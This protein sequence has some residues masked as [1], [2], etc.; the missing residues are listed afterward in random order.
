MV[1][2]DQRANT[3]SLHFPEREMPVGQRKKTSSTNFGHTCPHKQISFNFALLAGIL[4]P[5]N[6][7]K[8]VPLPVHIHCRPIFSVVSVF[9]KTCTTRTKFEHPRPHDQIF[10]NF[11]QFLSIFLGNRGSIR[12]GPNTISRVL[13]R[14]RELTRSEFW[15]KLGEFCEKLGEFALTHK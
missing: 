4:P 2:P 5:G 7:S 14:K 1:F 6:L 13:F 8:I 11:V 9:A 15:R 3:K 10:L 12:N